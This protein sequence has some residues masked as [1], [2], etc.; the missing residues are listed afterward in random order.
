VGA[1]AKPRAAFQHAD[2]RGR[3]EPHLRGE[4]PRLL[5]AIAEILGELGIEED[6]RLAGMHAVLRAA[7]AEDI[8]AR[9]PSHVGGAASEAGAGICETRP[10]HVEGEAKPAA[11]VRQGSDLGEGVD[12]PRLRRLGDR[13]D[14]RPGEMDVTAV[15][16][17]GA[18]RLRRQL[19]A[20]RADGEQFGA[21]GEEFRRPALICFDMG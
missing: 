8:D 21:V 7:E 13:H 11:L 12:L 20:L 17:Q 3:E 2:P 15:R 1:V 4:L 19:A 10:I 6:H 18:D 14:S 5:A 16:R 9:P